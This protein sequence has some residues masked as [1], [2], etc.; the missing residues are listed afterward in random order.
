MDQTT[1]ERRAIEREDS[2]AGDSSIMGS[3]QSSEM[4]QPAPVTIT[5]EDRRSGNHSVKGDKAFAPQ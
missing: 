4:S 3:L 1:R 2:S 5:G